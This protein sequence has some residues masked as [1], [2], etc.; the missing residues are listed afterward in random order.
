MT[1]LSLAFAPQTPAD[2]AAI[3][4]LEERA[5]GPGRFAKTAYRLREGVSPDLSLSTIARIG[6]MLVGACTLT[7]IAVGGAPVLLLGPLT[8]EEPFRARGVGEALAQRSL[9]AAKAAGH[10]LVLLVGDPPFYERLGFVRAGFGQFVFPGPVD[11]GRILFYE[12]EPD[13]KAR[14]RGLVTSG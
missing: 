12:L 13:A 7:R 14:C 4:K 1:E 2:L 11:P 5:F 3:Q 6:G 9:E 8:V 10:A